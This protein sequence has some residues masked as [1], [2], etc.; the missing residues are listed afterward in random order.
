M[1][2]RLCPGATKTSTVIAVPGLTR[3]AEKKKPSF[4]PDRATAMMLAMTTEES[5]ARARATAIVLV[6]QTGDTLI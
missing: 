3:V 1:G 5:L 2:R 6:T 4:A